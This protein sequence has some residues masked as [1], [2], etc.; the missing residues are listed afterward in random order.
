[1][2]TTE[3]L[4]AAEAR[5]VCQL[6]AERAIRVSRQPEPAERA[7]PILSRLLFIRRHTA[8]LSANEP[9]QSAA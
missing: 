4:E 7:R 6:A 2:K 1:M 8:A 3:W 9:L 5:R